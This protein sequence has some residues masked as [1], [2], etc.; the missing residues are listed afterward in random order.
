MATL[1]RSSCRHKE[2]V[3]RNTTF[4]NSKAA[5]TALRSPINTRQGDGPPPLASV[6]FKYTSTASFGGAKVETNSELLAMDHEF[7]NLS[8]RDQGEIL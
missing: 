2:L 8:T 1:V 3:I 7:G 5:G 4:T 6:K